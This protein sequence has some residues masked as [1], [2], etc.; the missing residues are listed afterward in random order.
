[1]RTKNGQLK[2]VITANAAKG[3]AERRRIV[4]LD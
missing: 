4:T 2:N 3:E 1:V